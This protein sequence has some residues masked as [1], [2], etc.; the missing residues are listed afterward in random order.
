MVPDKRPPIEVEVV[1]GHVLHALTDALTAVLL[2]ETAGPPVVM[3]GADD[4]LIDFAFGR[5]DLAAIVANPVDLKTKPSLD[6]RFADIVLPRR[7]LAEAL[8]CRLPRCRSGEGE[9][10]SEGLD[11]ALH[12]GA[13]HEST[14]L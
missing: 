14:S 5:F 12:C 4:G 10:Q 8:V 1:E 7:R 9:Q 2:I 13:F 6:P 11:L 3:F